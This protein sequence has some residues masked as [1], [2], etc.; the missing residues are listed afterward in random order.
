MLHAGLVSSKTVG[1]CCFFLVFY[2]TNR[3]HGACKATGGPVKIP[4]PFPFASRVLLRLN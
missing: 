3:D 4:F 2:T 1:C